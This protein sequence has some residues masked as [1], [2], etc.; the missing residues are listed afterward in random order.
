[1]YALNFFLLNDFIE[2]YATHFTHLS[3]QFMGIP[4]VAQWVKNPT[5]I[6]VHEDAGS[7]PGLA[8]WVKDPELP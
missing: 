2:L 6:S 3:V 4:F 8:Q 7:I 5:S 1:M